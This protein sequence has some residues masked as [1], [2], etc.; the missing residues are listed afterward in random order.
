MPPPPACATCGV[1]F[2]TPGDT[3]AHCGVPRPGFGEGAAPAGAPDR[4][5][6]GGGVVTALR[7]LT[8]VSLCLLA[9]S[10]CRR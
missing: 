9:L 8:F 7:W 6:R 10:Q 5:R 3:C 4:E 1:A 2:A